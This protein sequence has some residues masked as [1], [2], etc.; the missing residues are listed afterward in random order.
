MTE[1]PPIS[2]PVLWF[3]RYIARIYFRGHFTAV[4]ISNAHHLASADSGPL[5]VYANHAS[6]WD[7]MIEV[8]LAYRL[9]RSRNHYAPMNLIGLERHSILKKI[10][11]FGIDKGTARGGLIFLRTSL[12]ILAQKG[13]IWLTPQSRFA[14]ARER[15]LNFSRGIAQLATRCTGG[16][17]LVPL[18]VEYVFWDERRPEALIHVGEP[19]RINGGDPAILLPMLEEQL[20]KAMDQLREKAIARDPRAFEVLSK[21]RRSLSILGFSQRVLAWVRRKYFQAKRIRPTS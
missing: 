10:G 16:C 9:M 4:R 18:A 1:V 7:P 19:I 11:V 17:T 21:G 8:I 5:I 2:K 20:L 14:D 6:W 13:V 3:F 15:P 12:A